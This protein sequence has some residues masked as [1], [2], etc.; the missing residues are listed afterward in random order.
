M[1]KSRA[2]LNSILERTATALRHVAAAADARREPKSATTTVLSSDPH[3]PPQSWFD[4]LTGQFGTAG[5]DVKQY[6]EAVR[7]GGAYS[8][9]VDY[10]PH[11]G[12]QSGGD[13]QLQDILRLGVQSVNGLADSTE[14]GGGPE[15]PKTVYDQD[16]RPVRSDRDP[17]SIF[18]DPYARAQQL[19]YRERPRLIP[20]A[21]IDA[22]IQRTPPMVAL[23]QTQIANVAKHATRSRSRF[24]QGFRVK[25]ADHD[26]HPTAADRKEMT[27]IENALLHTGFINNGRQRDTFEG[28][29]R[30]IVNDSL[31]YDALAFE[32]VPDRRGRPVEWFA[33]DGRAVRLAETGASFPVAD[34]DAIRTV[35]L[36]ENMII[37]KFT[38]RELAYEPR[39]PRSDIRMLGYGVPEIEMV[40]LMVTALLNAQNHNRSQFSNGVQARGLLA[41]MGQLTEQQLKGFRAEWHQ[42]LSGEAGAFRTPIVNTQDV[43]WIPM[44]S[45]NREMEFSAWMEFL[46]RVCAAVY[47]M[48]PSEINFKMGNSGG[49]KSSMFESGQRARV[50]ES[51]ERGLKP[52]MRFLSRIIDKYIIEPR[53]PE[54][55]IEF[56]G[57]DSASPKELADLYTQQSRSFMYVDEVRALMDYPPLDNGLGRNIL[58]AN[59]MNAKASMEQKL[60]TEK[61][62]V[63]QQEQMLAQQDA[64]RDAQAGK[65]G[66]A[67]L[68]ALL[69]QLEAGGTGVKETRRETQTPA[70][71]SNESRGVYVEGET[72]Q[73]GNT[74]DLTQ[75]IVSQVLTA[76]DSA[77]LERLI[78]AAKR[79]PATLS[80]MTIEVE[81]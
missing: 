25:L 54:F 58:D 73:T 35:A 64:V 66:P 8:T 75:A 11:G 44:N 76:E 38:A 57:L 9:L 63:Q 77:S 74:P 22:L 72:G 19:G 48:D 43:K 70:D 55:C 2:A 52:L 46:L 1:S 65:G 5:V 78:K 79:K 41:L 80:P 40:V 16:G 34:R 56:T 10:N 18:A 30:K 71:I 31:R 24:E 68:E 13:Q 7:S 37:G 49:G 36:Y 47:Q 20:D 26:A 60:E 69:A 67:G 15:Q 62:N 6:E 33:V 51:R 61:Q 23:I 81:V 59:W 29:L 27:R 17:K 39:N 21:G 45:S 32:V 14:P 53:A 3:V 50:Q 28:F 12:Q 4:A 42:M